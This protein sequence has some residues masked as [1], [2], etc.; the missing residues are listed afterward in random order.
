MPSVAH[1]QNAGEGSA[2]ATVLGFL[3][4]FLIGVGIPFAISF[5]VRTV[6]KSNFKAYVGTYVIL[7]TGYIILNT[8][9]EELP[10]SDLYTIAANLVPLSMFGSFLAQWVY[11]LILPKKKA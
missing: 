3:L 4:L 7:L 9:F 10:G 6:T 2:E 5:V 1:A 8:I 11:Y